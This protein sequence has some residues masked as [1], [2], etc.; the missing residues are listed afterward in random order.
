MRC[1]SSPPHCRAAIRSRSY[2]QERRPVARGRHLAI[3]EDAFARRARA[4][5]GRDSDAVPGGRDRQPS[6]RSGPLHRRWYASEQPDQ[7]GAQSGRRE[8]DR[9]RAGAVRCRRRTISTRRFPVLA[10]VAA[11][12]LDGLLVD[13]VAYD[14]RRMAA[15]NSFF[16][17]GASTGTSRAARAYRIA[18]GHSPYRP[19]S[20]ALVAPRQRGAIG[21]LA[22]RVFERRF[23]GMRGVRDLDYSSCRERWEDGRV[24][25]ASCFRFSCSIRCSWPS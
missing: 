6:E 4:G 14:L 22:E 18:R 3:R 7:T 25:A 11:N 12:V 19:I 20:Y 9:G 1:V 23:G 10:D 15:I 21:R 5:I 2:P 24:P 8:G 17:E 16:A 13:Q